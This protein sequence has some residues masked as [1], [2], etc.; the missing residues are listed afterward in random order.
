MS[1][2]ERTA[3]ADF[4]PFQMAIA[5]FRYSWRISIAVAMGV[6]VATAVMVG[7]LLVGDSMRGSLR[8]LT[9]QRLGKI[10]SILAPNQFFRFRELLD[11]NDTGYAP[12]IFFSKG[13]I[14][15]RVSADSVSRSGRVQIIGCDSSF[16]SMDEYL[17]DEIRDLTENGVAL[18]Q[19][20]ADEL[21]VVVG[22]LVTVRLPVEQAVPADSP[23]GRKESNSE[24]LPRLKVAQIIPDRGLGRFSLSASQAVPFNVF[25]NRELIA[26]S[27]DRQGQANMILFDKV[28]S[29][30]TLS[31]S[32]SSLGLNL[33]KISGAWIDQDGKEQEVFSYRS[34][35]S[36]SLL[37]PDAVVQQILEDTENNKAIPQCTYLAN[38][39]DHLDESGNLLKSIPYS[40]ITAVDSSDDLSLDFLL[41]AEQQK[42]GFVPVV[43]N[44]WAASQLDAEIGDS[45][46]I[47]YFEPE[48]DDGQEVERYFSAV[49]TSI[50]PL[51]QPSEPYRRRRPAIYR[52]QLSRYNDPGLTPVVPGVTDQNSISDWDL[53]FKLTRE[54]TKADDEYWND[55]RLTPKLFLPLDAG[56]KYFGSRFGLITGIRFPESSDESIEDLSKRLSASVRPVLSKIGWTIL[57]IRSDQLASAGGTTPFDGLFLALSFF[58]I[59]ASVLLIAMLF[60]LGLLQRIQQ[61]GVLR[62]A[63]WSPPAL[64]R[65]VFTEG[66]I[67]ALAG[68]VMGL[69]FGVLYS[70]IILHGLRTWWVGAVTVPFL[71][72]HW[73]FRSLFLGGFL[74]LFIALITIRF[75]LRWIATSRPQ[76][77][78]G[79]RNPDDN[80]VRGSGSYTA[81]RSSVFALMLIAMGLGVV[82]AMT[83][84]QIAAGAFVGSGM[85]LLASSLAGHFLFLCRFGSQSNAQ[86]YFNST[87]SL[88]VR[89]LA[90]YPMRSTMTVG[91]IASA[92]FLIFAIAA[93]QLQ[94]SDEGTGGFSLIGESSQPVYENLNDTSVR[95]QLMGADAEKVGNSVIQMFRLKLGQDASCNNLYQAAQP[96][97]LGVPDSFQKLLEDSNLKGFRWAKGPE[98][99]NSKMNWDALNRDATGTPE[100][101]IPIVLDQNT[102]MWSLQMMKGIGET[103]SFEFNPEDPKVFEVVGLLSNSVLQGKVLLSESNFNTLFP[104]VNGYQFFMIGCESDKLNEVQKSMELRFSDIGMDLSDASDTLAR[105]LAVQNTYLKT[106]Q[107]LGAL[108]L[109]LGTFGLGIAQVRS[110]LERQGELAILRS[111]GFSIKKL[112]GLVLCETMILLIF[113]VGL[114]F[115]CA[116]LAVLPHALIAGIDPPVLEPI[117]LSLMIITLGICT[118]MIS[119]RAVSRL[120]LLESLR[121]EMH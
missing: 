88:A 92:A 43:L 82:G 107:S 31:I 41:T 102:A 4:S 17:T 70:I 25:M 66:T 100:D 63:G 111:F 36:D 96:T 34:L 29:M 116:I 45:L 94:P 42:Q 47:A 12:I 85:S 69:I 79:G 110:V 7:A 26:D 76:Q 33:S 112:S 113:G 49:V 67:T 91:L 75:S 24:G 61:Y 97:V 9:L 118:S 52:Q 89:N 38:A 59:A 3:R 120:P 98:G 23:L 80:V 10:Q 55:H 46:R 90:R 83:G 6:G 71:E 114:G 48:V 64:V 19:A 56:R 39:I 35:T 60:K 1:E 77:L 101:P 58:V 86:S 62:V 44:Q 14:E 104:E 109:L 37:V 30:D 65:Y 15:H 72:F 27:L 54:I 32:L 8:D 93:F 11:S 13:I 105:M 95:K 121:K 84:G 117:L 68:M 20:A 81:L 53:P 21:G 2:S 99:V 22:D 115:V 87:R 106:F 78:M 73:T 28:V 74:G 16:W 57:P 40:T 108:G 18:N 119:V 5:S 50:V 103:K 51:V